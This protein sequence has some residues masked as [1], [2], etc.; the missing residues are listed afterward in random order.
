MGSLLLEHPYIY[1]VHETRAPSDLTVFLVCLS[2]IKSCVYV[3]VYYRLSLELSV[4]HSDAALF[5]KEPL[6]FPLV[7][8]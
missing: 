3:K 8:H 6:F 2:F 1:S 5:P 7:F 4:K